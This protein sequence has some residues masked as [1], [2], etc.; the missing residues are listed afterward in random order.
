MT[1]ETATPQRRRAR[2]WLGLLGLIVIFIGVNAAYPLVATNTVTLTGEAGDVL[3]VATFDAF[4]EDW[5]Q[6][7]GRDSHIVSDENTLRIN[8]QT[9]SVIYSAAAPHFIDFD[10]A[11]S[12]R[13][14]DGSENNAYGMVFRLQQ[15]ADGCAMSFAILCGLA[16]V[17]PLGIGRWVQLAF[18]PEQVTR[19]Y[20]FLISSD[21]YYS[22]WR[23][24]ESGTKQLSAWIGSEAITQGMN[25]DN[26]IRVVGRGDAFQFF[27]NGEAVELCIPDDPEATSTYA[28]GQCFEGSMRRTLLDDS[29]SSG[30]LG[31]VVSTQGLVPGVTV[32]F[33]N[34]IVTSPT[35][36]A[37]ENPA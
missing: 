29:I 28:M 30:Q 11:M 36:E 14:I 21:G 19:F 32:D 9:E 7:T 18:E 23:G 31:A 12:T 16:E 13:A 24:D 26:Q 27:I 35:S 1:N 20:M 15:P 17:R 10:A 33:D 22:V 4:N 37:E 5:E 3:Y 6:S 34:I 2:R 25:A 8:V